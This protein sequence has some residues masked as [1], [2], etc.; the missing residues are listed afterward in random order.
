M[1][2]FFPLIPLVHA[3]IEV[4]DSYVPSILKLL[5]PDGVA[6]IHHS[7]FKDSGQ[8]T[9]IHNRSENVTAGYVRSVIELNGGSVLTQEKINWGSNLLID[10]LT[11]FGNKGSHQGPVSIDNDRFMDEAENC[12]RV[13]NL[14]CSDLVQR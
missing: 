7:N 9:N 6:F 5:G 8:A 11:T 3:D 14:Y 12:K 13:V 10:C 2:L 4:F 1:T